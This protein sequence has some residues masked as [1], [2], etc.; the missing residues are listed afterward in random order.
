MSVTDIKL[1]EMFQL[2]LFLD[3]DVVDNWKEKT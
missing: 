1:V 3:V 2:T